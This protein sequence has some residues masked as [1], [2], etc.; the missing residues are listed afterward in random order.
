MHIDIQYRIANNPNY[1]R[2]L[3]ENSYWYKYLNRNRLYFKDFDNSMKKQYKLTT[4]D[5]IDKMR[6]GIDTISK[7]MEILRNNYH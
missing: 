2:F 7:I 4:E 1:K 6:E 3:E 5:R